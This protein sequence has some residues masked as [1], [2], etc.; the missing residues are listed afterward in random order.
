MC[1]NQV[2]SQPSL[3][4][5]SLLLCRF[6]FYFQPLSRFMRPC[7]IQGADAAVIIA[8]SKR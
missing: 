1:D 3:S 4:F 7:L 2:T 6:H 8:C 5:G